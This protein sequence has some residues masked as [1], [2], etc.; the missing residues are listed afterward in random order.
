[1][2]ILKVAQIGNPALRRR[3]ETVDEQTLG[4]RDFRRL[5]DDLVE[6]MREY[7]GVGLAAPQVRVSLRLFVM[8]VAASERYPDIEPVPLTV[9]INPE[10]QS[11]ETEFVEDWEGCLS[12]A[13]LR[14]RVPRHPAVHL[15][16]LNRSGEAVDLQLEG[17]PARIAQHETDHLNGTVFLD[18]MTDMS[19]LMDEEEY[20]RMRAAELEDG[21]NDDGDPDARQRS[22]GAR[23]SLRASS[24][25]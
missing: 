5:I 25:A 12:L 1:M 23:V 14:G 4:D 15:H 6:T 9:V 19:S 22:S 24:E 10:L 3:S 13:G 7:E 11:R 2:A 20:R 17:F 16:G 8:E 21:G 18:R